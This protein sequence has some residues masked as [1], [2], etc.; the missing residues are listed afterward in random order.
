M[1]LDQLS[2]LDSSFVWFERP[3]APAVVGAVSTFEA[4]PLLDGRGRLRLDDLRERTAARLDALPRL[5]RRLAVVPYDLGRPAW[6]DDPDFDIANHVRELRLPPPGDDAALRRAAEDLHGELLPRDRPLWDLTIVTG[7]DGHRVGLVERIHHALVDGVGGVDLATILMDLEPDAP[8]VPL[9]PWS[10]QPWPSDTELVAASV[11]QQLGDSARV[12]G[13][14]ARAVR[15]PLRG[16]QAAAGL[17][18]GL[19]AV[20]DDGLLAP[21][22]S[23][24]G[25]LQGG[26]RLAWVRARLD[27]VKT[28]AHRAGGSVNDVMLAV[29]GGGLRALFLGRGEPLPADLVLKV[30]V[31]VSFRTEDEHGALGNRVGAVYA[32][33]PVGVGDPEARLAAIV[34]TMRRLKSRPEAR[35]TE[36]LLGGADVLPAGA[37]H[38]ISRAVLHQPFVNLVVT[39]VP[40]PPVPL[41]AA[42]ARMLDAFPVV[43]LGANLTVGVAVLSYD[44]AL[45][46]SVTA[47]A[48]ACPDVDVFGEGMERSLAGYLG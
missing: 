4:A 12:V 1:T 33:L 5:R 25:P 45:T 18:R 37:A 10:A 7:L 32:P 23:L 35:T 11:R 9:R 14:A 44:G 39:N 16:L 41:Y 8:A 40:G 17:G 26:R 6:I 34:A 21:H 27:E 38:L 3:E 42:G 19:T 48:G 15:H 13:A 28:A 30:L 29:V 43:P 47:D 36:A 2:A 46:I 22:T 24:N 31:P 20:A